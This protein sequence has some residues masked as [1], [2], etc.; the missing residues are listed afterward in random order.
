MQRIIAAVCCAVALGGCTTSLQDMRAEGPEK[1]FTTQKPEQQVAECILYAW[2]N[3]SL[4]GVHYAVSLQPRPGGGK[5]VVNAGNREMA[6]VIG[7]KGQTVVRFYT[8]GSMGWII[9]RRVASAKT[10]L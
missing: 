3:Q 7:E 4:A 8:S 6:D 1:T 9:D 2:Q 10:C 5:S